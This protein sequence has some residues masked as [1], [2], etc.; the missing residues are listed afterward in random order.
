VP[1]HASHKERRW[2]RLESWWAD[3]QVRPRVRAGCGNPSAR[4]RQ[5]RDRPQSM[6]RRRGRFKERRSADWILEVNARP[7]GSPI[8]RISKVLDL[9]GTP[10]LRP[11]ARGRHDLYRVSRCD[12]I[13][14]SGIR[15]GTWNNLA[16]TISSGWATDLHE[17]RACGG[18][19]VDLPVL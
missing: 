16:S 17:H 2:E 6:P 10:V 19:D 12:Q 15:L 4:S 13:G 3:N 11:S 5:W 1:C 8:D 7:L 14:E 18:Q 9:Q